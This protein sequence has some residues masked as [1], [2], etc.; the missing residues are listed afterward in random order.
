MVVVGARHPIIER[1][2]EAPDGSSGSNSRSGELFG[3]A[4]SGLVKLWDLRK[5]M[6]IKE[7]QANGAINSLDF[8]HSGSYLASAADDIELRHVKSWA[9]LAKLE[10]HSKAVRGVKWSHN[11]TR[12]A[13][14]SMDKCL[15]IFGI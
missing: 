15:K 9:A 10:S 1:L 2:L 7:F 4:A 13:S 11:A 3:G 14:A 5:L 12:L 8:D 6:A